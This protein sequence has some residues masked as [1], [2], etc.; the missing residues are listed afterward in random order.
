MAVTNGTAVE[1]R[2]KAL[3]LVKPAE[4]PPATETAPAPPT[5][6]ADTKAERQRL[7]R[8][9]AVLADDRTRELF[10]FA[11]R[12]GS[13]TY[14]GIRIVAARSWDSRTTA[15]YE[16]NMRTAEAAGNPE[17]IAEWEERAHRFRQARHQRRVDMLTAMRQAPK[18][19]GAATG[20]GLG[21]LLALGA[22]LAY[23]TGDLS[24]VTAP[25]MFVVD[26]LRWA[27]IIGTVVWGVGK[28][29][30]PAL[31]LATFWR[32]G[33]QRQAAPRWALPANVRGDGEPITP[34]IVVLALRH[35][36][37]PALRKAIV[38]MEDGGAS[39]L[40]PIAIAGCGVELDAYLPLEVTTEEVMGRRRKFAENLGRH[41]HEVYIS[42]APAP[43]T[44]R[45]WIADSGALDEPVP[46]SPLVTD[47]TLTA[48][49]KTGRAPWGPNLRGD[50]TLIS[51]YQKHVLVTG[52]SNQGKTAALR[53]LALWLALDPTVEFWIADLK[54]VGDWSMFKGI[55][56]V[57]IEGPTDD[58]VRQATEI[59][60]EALAEQNRRLLDK[61]TTHRPLIVIVDEAQIAYGSGA[62]G[63]DGRPYGGQKATSRYFNGVKGI[64]DQGRAVDVLMWEGTQDP[65]DQNLPKRSREG[66]H[67]RASLALGTESQAAMALGETPVLK[68]A[69]PHKLRLG[70][71]KGQLVAAGEG[72]PLDPG[73]PSVNVRTHYI[74]TDDAKMIADRARALREHVETVDNSERA[75]PRDHLTD[76][77][78]VIHAH[79][80]RVK[81]TEAVRRLKGLSLSEYGH[82]FGTSLTQLLQKYGEDTGVH[83]GILTVTRERVLRALQRRDEGAFDDQ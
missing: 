71:D 68:G 11:V 59:V 67:I 76:L 46:P 41:E 38:A 81:A 13:Y 25:L 28:M 4:T 40:S 48:N 8:I 35:L 74:S 36:G 50:S 69:A 53:S 18:A 54:G 37:I 47:P 82:W 16:R 49:Y 26:L 64:H 45:L 34:S 44:I 29:F 63:A 56:T 30:L 9:R 75:E 42:V 15:R 57:L 78:A 52:A 31:A 7:R 72:V 2:A 43:R 23:A 32:V 22:G 33:Q 80:K 1:E 77:A 61:S 5:P 20:T 79:E 70:L 17:Q 14:S 62:K 65:T 12:H 27:V 73:Q 24:Q 21:V 58:H 39:M 6:A 60:E 10:R 19:V 66:N 3:K 51:L 55:A 83:D